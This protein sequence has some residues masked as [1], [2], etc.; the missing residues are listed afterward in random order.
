MNTCK[1]YKGQ[2]NGNVVEKKDKSNWYD[3][4]WINVHN[5][6]CVDKESTKYLI[7]DDETEEE[8]TVHSL[9]DIEKKITKTLVDT[10]FSQS[11]YYEDEEAYIYW[12]LSNEDY[13]QQMLDHPDISISFIINIIRPLMLETTYVDN[14]YDDKYDDV[15]ERPNVDV[16]LSSSNKLTYDMIV[17]YKHMID[18]DWDS[19]AE[20]PSIDID[21][22]MSGKHFMVK[23]K[24]VLCNPAL[25]ETQ[26]K[27]YNLEPLALRCMCI[28]RSKPGFLEP[29][30]QYYRE[31]MMK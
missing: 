12:E 10:C 24:Y 8:Y 31:N 7:C 1:L 30:R 14:E 28:L 11:T 13:L 17:Q 16:I 23:P 29:Y 19:I 22:M 26:F 2:L 9:T 15:F 5:S 25:T 6:I 18:W 27:Q 20:N 3:D 4:E 21:K